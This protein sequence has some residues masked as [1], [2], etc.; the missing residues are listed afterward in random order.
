MILVN[1]R[2]HEIEMFLRLLKTTEAPQW[3]LLV[4]ERNYLRTYL[5]DRQWKG[6]KLNPA[7][8]WWHA[9]E[10]MMVPVKQIKCSEEHT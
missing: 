2:H 7:V 6:N 10:N 8:W 1:F 4:L 3:T 5:T 9:K